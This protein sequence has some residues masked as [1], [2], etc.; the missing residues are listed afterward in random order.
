[1]KRSFREP[2][3]AHLLTKM[4]SFMPSLPSVNEIQDGCRCRC[5]LTFSC[6]FQKLALFMKIEGIMIENIAVLFG[7]KWSQDPSKKV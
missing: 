4:A 7:I 6:S 2:A 5:D 1:M 3:V